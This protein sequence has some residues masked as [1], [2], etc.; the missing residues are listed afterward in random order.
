MNSSEVAEVENGGGGMGEGDLVWFGKEISIYEI[1]KRGR[2]TH[3][4]MESM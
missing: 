1:V 3:R 4:Y 2:A